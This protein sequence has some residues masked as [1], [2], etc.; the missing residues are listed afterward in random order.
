MLKRL[1]FALLL[2]I[3][4]AAPAFALQSNGCMPLTGTVTGLQLS[5]NINT[6]FANINSMNSG[7]TA[8][9]TDCSGAT[10][11]GQEWLDTSGAFP[12]WRVWDGTA[13]LGLAFL[14]ATNHLLYPVIGG[15]TATLT[16][17]ATTD[18]CAGVPQDYLTISGGTA[19]TS[20]GT[21]CAVGQ[22]KFLS[23]AGAT[24]ITFGLGSILTQTSQSITTAN[25]DQA[26]AVYL[27][28]GVWRILN[29]QL[30]AGARLYYGSI[31][32]GTANALTV[33]S[34]TPTDFVLQ[35]GARVT[36]FVGSQNT[37]AATLNVASTGVKNILKTT[38]GGNATLAGGEMFG[39]VD[40]IYDGTEYILLNEPAIPSGMIS[41]FP[42]TTCPAGWAAAN[43]SNGTVNLVG[44][45]IRSWDPLGAV[46]QTTG[47]AIGSVEQHAFESH[48][49]GVTGGT[50]AG[51]FG[52]G[53]TN[54]PQDTV[55]NPIAIQVGAPNSG[56]V[57]SE[58]RPS[59]VA[60][61]ACQKL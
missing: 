45:F 17:A 5:Q 27:G 14:D 59:N 20:L 28:G 60:L 34:T 56:N 53:S 32:G 38:V 46:D 52:G 10:V 26:Q 39:A 7:P 4:A 9:A 43:G 44:Y 15:G 41:Y 16:A 33:G 37:G 42:A 40:V 49:H 58:T 11:V 2:T 30:A 57:S 51:T 6:A 54:G 24:P 21:S 47:R 12:V 1:L 3:A 8:P 31:A 61:L 25:G 36:F 19:I 55:L 48:T 18:L 22:I 29:Y 35:A 13:G 23:F 50:I